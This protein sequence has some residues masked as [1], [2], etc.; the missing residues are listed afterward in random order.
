MS[1]QAMGRFARLS[2]SSQSREFQPISKPTGEGALEIRKVDHPLAVVISEDC[3]LEQ[4]FDLRFPTDG[5]PV[6]RDAA[7]M[8]HRSISLWL[9]GQAKDPA[10]SE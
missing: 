5:E 7:D 8:S 1:R 6:E 2:F 3:D 4:D 10:E 9:E